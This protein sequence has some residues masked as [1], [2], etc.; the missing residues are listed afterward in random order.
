MRAILEVAAYQVLFLDRV[1]AHAAIKDAVDHV[2]ELLPAA[3]ARGLA[4]VVNATLRRLAEARIAAAAA[5]EIPALPSAHLSG[6]DPD[7]H[8]LAV[9]WSHPAWLVG[10]WLARFGPDRTRALL[11]ADNRPPGVHLRPHSGRIAG[12]ELVQRLE[13][14]GAS[15]EPHPLHAGSLTLRSGDPA[16]LDAFREG[17]FTV[18]DVSAQMVSRLVPDDSSGLFVDV[19]AAPG[20]KIGAAAERPEGRT[21]VAADISAVRLRRIVDTARRQ[22]LPLRAVVADAR[23]LALRRA[24]SFVLA[25]VPCLGT[26]T[27]RRRADARWRLSRERL[28][29]LLDLQRGILANAADLLAPG[30][31]IL[32]AT[33]SLEAEE[34]EQM[35]AWLL[36][37][38]PDL[39]PVNLEP[40]ISPS[41][42][43]RL[44]GRAECALFVTP[45][46]GDCDGAF[47]VLLEKAA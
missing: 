1:P 45:E 11:E 46:A 40:L 38:R 7:A 37:S 31:R 36:S 22:D 2:R 34:N 17:L 21:F 13:R 27:L 28:A 9:A 44:P 12:T 14:D 20:G 43:L 32:Y 6:A 24:P 41:L 23:T 4:G 26:G 3:Q 16:A 47:A 30:G 5:E 8:E 10:R 39:T 33:C 29:D 42:A 35:V 25:D 18:Q 15:V 19:C